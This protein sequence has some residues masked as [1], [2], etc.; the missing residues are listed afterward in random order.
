MDLFSLEGKNVAITGASSGFGHHFAG[1]L[2]KAG[3]NVLLGA[4]RIDKIN[5]RVSEIE[6]TGARAIALCLDVR[7]SESCREFLVQGE[8]ALGSIDVLVNN[9]FELA[10]DTFTFISSVEHTRRIWLKVEN[11]THGRNER[12][13]YTFRNYTYSVI[14]ILKELELKN[15][16]LYAAKYELFYNNSNGNFKVLFEPTQKQIELLRL[17]N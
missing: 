15:P 16:D 13:N 12:L 11:I 4:R 2:S 1:V 8:Q 17:L 14:P 3:A 9:A 7:D 5:Q 6:K 10:N